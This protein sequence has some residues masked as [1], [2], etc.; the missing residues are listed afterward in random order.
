MGEKVIAETIRQ[1][2]GETP[3]FEV[4]QLRRAEPRLT[5]RMIKDR[6]GTDGDV[7]VDVDPA[8]LRLYVLATRP[9][10]IQIKD[11]V[12]QLEAA[13]CPTRNSVELRQISP[14]NENTINRPDAGKSQQLRAT[15]GCRPRK[16]RS[17][18]DHQIGNRRRPLLAPVGPVRIVH[19]EGTNLLLIR[20]R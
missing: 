13:A 19:I 9:V 15:R 16:R 17:I 12:A 7:R 20:G 10:V 8:T 5:V 14:K 11:F 18:T 4:I 2:K 3:V 6:F 1:L